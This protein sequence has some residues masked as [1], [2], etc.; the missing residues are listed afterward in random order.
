MRPGGR[1]KRLLKP[2]EEATIRQAVADGLNWRQVAELIG[3]SYSAI[4]QRREDQ[5]RDLRVGRG[6]GR[7]SRSSD[8]TEEEIEVAAALLRRKWTDDRWG[9][10]EPT[11]TPRSGRLEKF[12]TIHRAG[13]D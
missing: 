11:S 12:V 7:K 3:W 8:P 5:L 10:G 4:R 6:R 2:E 13:R 1:V 9:I